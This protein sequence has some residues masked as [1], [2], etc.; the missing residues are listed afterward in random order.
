MGLRA[1]FKEDLQATPSELIYGVNM[2][3]PGE[4]FAGELKQVSQT[5][6]VKENYERTEAIASI[7]IA[8]PLQVFLRDDA[9]RPPLKQPYEGPYEILSRG[10]KTL[11][12]RARGRTVNVSIDRVKPVYF[13]NEAGEGCLQNNV[14]VL[15]GNSNKQ[16]AP[17]V[18]RVGRA[19]RFPLRFMM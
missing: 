2:R 4:M 19:V 16:I 6:F 11:T 7:A 3:L 9:V 13:G 18:T 10:E 12:I 5:E 8:F 14:K 17:K 15:G 1:A